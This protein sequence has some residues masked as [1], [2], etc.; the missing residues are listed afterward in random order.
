MPDWEIRNNLNEL[1][2]K[3]MRV[4]VLTDERDKH[5]ARIKEINR[6]GW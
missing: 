2:N 1:E 6:L 3:L 4:T 5:L